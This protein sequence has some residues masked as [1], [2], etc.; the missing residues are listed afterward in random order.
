MDDGYLARGSVAI[1]R[2]I[3]ASRDSVWDAL[4]TPAAMARWM[5]ASSDAEG[6]AE[7]DLRVGG[8]YRVYAPFDGG[9]HQGDGWSGMCGIYVEVAPPER[10]VFTMHWDAD[11]GYN[12]AGLLAL[13][14]VIA[15]TLTPEGDGTRVGWTRMGVPD[16]G[17][18]IEGHTEGDTVTLNALAV[19][20]EG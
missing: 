8:A 11:I 17:R 12:R 14:E 6:W 1:E 4:T 19:V 5:W 18:S 20:L 10:L 2:L 15:I 3:D 13:D 16:D 7:A 9:T